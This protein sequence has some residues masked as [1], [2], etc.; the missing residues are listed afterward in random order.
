MKRILS[1]CLLLA[2]GG[3]LAVAGTG[4][5]T[6]LPAESHTGDWPGADGVAAASVGYLSERN[7]RDWARDYL[8]RNSGEGCPDDYRGGDRINN[9][10]WRLYYRSDSPFICEHDYTVVV[11]RDENPAGSKYTINLSGTETTRC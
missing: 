9:S 8:C 4:C 3:T 10:A 6:A 1:V 5:E 2:V 7:A 11:D